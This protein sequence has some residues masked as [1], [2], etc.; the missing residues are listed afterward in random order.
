MNISAQGTAAMSTSATD[1]SV[2]QI[3]NA[4]CDTSKSY[5]YN[6]K[7]FHR[8]HI[9][10]IVFFSRIYS[11]SR[12]LQRSQK[13]VYLWLQSNYNALTNVSLP[14][15]EIVVTFIGLCG[16]QTGCYYTKKYFHSKFK[17]ER[18][19]T[20]WCG[21]RKWSNIWFYG[22]QCDASIQTFFGQNV[23][24]EPQLFKSYDLN[25]LSYNAQL[26]RTV[27][28][29]ARKTLELIFSITSKT[30]F[31]KIIEITILYVFK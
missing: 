20:L 22:F 4:F 3:V 21:K 18:W 6:E 17:F 29:V 1:C 10:Q 16:S 19:Y 13:K 8:K 12:L 2:N 27:L 25:R 28:F 5:V 30:F 23:E 26:K 9:E 11:E 24:L 31:N 7:I 14:N 15:N